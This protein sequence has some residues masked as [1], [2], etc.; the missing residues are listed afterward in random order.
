M[1]DYKFLMTNGKPYDYFHYH[2]SADEFYILPVLIVASAL[3][4]FLLF[5]T[6]W[7]AVALKTRQLFHVTYKLFLNTVFLHCIGCLILCTHYAVYG[8]D[9]VGLPGNKLFGRILES[10][11]DIT[12]VLLLILLAKGYTITRARLRQAS[13]IKVTMFMCVY[14]VTYACLF[15]FEQ[16]YFD[17]GQVL[18]VYQ[19]TAGYGLVILRFV[20]WV[21]FIYSTFFTL[22][23]YPDKGAFYYPFF[24]FYTLWFCAGPCIILISNYIIAEWVREKVVVSVE[25][26]VAAAGHICLLV[27]TRPSAHNKN[28]PYHVRTTQIGIMEAMTTNTS[29]GPNTLDR[30][31]NVGTYGINTATSMD[32]FTV[33]S[34]SRPLPPPPPYSN[35]HVPNGIPQWSITNHT[36]PH[37]V[38]NGTSAPPKIYDPNADDAD[39]VIS[40]E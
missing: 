26:F 7:F 6:T 40:R 38:Q 20:A 22:K 35:P 18:Y 11:A 14:C 19:S 27:L 33:D 3:H 30:F 17:P 5:T 28:F 29:V 23:H 32:M 9:G 8:I 1:G 13:S 34:A 37:N 31:A 24:C 16:V 10:A 2:F 4:L 25:H 39:S 21:M 12:L 15:I 36:V